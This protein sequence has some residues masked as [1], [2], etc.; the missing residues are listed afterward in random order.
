VPEGDTIHRAAASLRAALRDGPITAFE[1]PGVAGPRPR[2]GE[3]IDRIQARGKHLL[4]HFSGGATLHTHLGMTG[5]WRLEPRAPR[6]TP[7][8]GNPATPARRTALVETPRAAAFC[9]SAPTIELLDDAALRRH[10]MLVA[11][12]PDLCLADP[13]LDEVLRRLEDLDGSTPIG[14]ALL[15]QRVA[16][17]IGNVYRSEVLWACAIDPAAPTGSIRDDTRRTLFTTAS[18]LL[19]RNLQG[20]P[21]R[22]TAHGLAVYDR[23]G[24]TCRRCGTTIVVRRLGEQARTVFWCPGCQRLGAD[25]TLPAHGSGRP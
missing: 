16:A 18:D 22:T 10:P 17:G 2:P 6:R 5:S 4:M 25:A 15:D 24:R 8:K 23:A 9:R 11:L 21:R 20:W 14:V 19:R 1:A 13:D 3:T 7:A 12:G